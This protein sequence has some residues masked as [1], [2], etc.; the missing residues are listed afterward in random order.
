MLTLCNSHS[1]PGLHLE[2]VKEGDAGSGRPLIPTRYVPLAQKTN[3]QQRFRMNP[4]TNN[5]NA[6]TD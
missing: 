6:D 3:S 1:F 4:S 5:K 2:I